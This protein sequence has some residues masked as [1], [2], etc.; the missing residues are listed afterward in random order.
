MGNKRLLAFIAFASA[1]LSWVPVQAGEF[2][3]DDEVKL[4]RDIPLHFMNKPH[5]EG[6]AGEQFKVL[7]YKA[8]TRRVYL[9]ARED[10]KDI[11][12]TVDEEAVVLLPKDV[13]PIA[14]QARVSAEAGDYNSARKLLASAQRTN[15]QD[16]RIIQALDA[17]IRVEAHTRKLLQA[18]V[19]L[20]GAVT[21]A[22]RVR[23]NAVV[24]DRPNLLDPGDT[25]N[26]T[27]AAALREKADG[28]ENNAKAL[29]AK[30]EA[31]LKQDLDAIAGKPVNMQHAA[32]NQQAQPEWAK[33]EEG[34]PPM[35]D[36]DDDVAAYKDTLEFINNKLAGNWRK[37]WFGK[38]SGKFIVE[39]E[40]GYAAF[41]AADLTPDVKFSR[42]PMQSKL[43]PQFMLQI[44]GRNGRKVID[45]HMP[46]KSLVGQ[47]NNLRFQASDPV[48]QKKLVTA[49]SSLIQ[50][51][52]GKPDAFT[53]EEK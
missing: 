41:K 50:M 20:A 2:F 33:D 26:Q 44:E 11:A 46:G 32:R 52:G 12:L 29:V 36:G 19:A 30:I 5:R 53:D 35:L 47:S 8:E 17:L 40:N 38:N 7:A 15:R 37:I 10:G 21:E 1:T 34:I 43:G 48:D 9:L 24:V 45:V 3:A 6:T 42:E 39:G 49:F 4:L 23:K 14:A 16:P 31:E 28:V 13:G 27:R 18:K 22:S 51:L 25:S